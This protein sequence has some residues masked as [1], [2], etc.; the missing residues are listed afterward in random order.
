MMMS[1]MNPASD[2]R[3]MYGILA[4]ETLNRISTQGEPEEVQSWESAYLSSL[5][6]LI[7]MYVMDAFVDEEP[8]DIFGSVD[9]ELSGNSVS[10]SKSTSVELF[11]LF[12][13]AKTVAFP[14]IDKAEAM[15]VVE[16]VVYQLFGLKSPYAEPTGEEIHATKRFFEALVNQLRT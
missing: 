2:Y 7:D 15:Q 16:K 9:N 6:R 14:Q 11:E 1:R 8:G 4:K 5:L 10:P 3:A 13:S 12:E